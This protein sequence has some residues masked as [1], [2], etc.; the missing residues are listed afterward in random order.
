MVLVMKKSIVLAG[1]LIM[2][3]GIIVG[4]KAVQAQSPQNNNSQA[5][6]NAFNSDATTLRLSLNTLLKE[7]AILGGLMLKA[8]YR[9]EDTTRLM[10]LMN[11]NQA[12]LEQIV[13]DAYGEDTRDRFADL[14]TQHIEEYESYTIAK[15]DNDEERMNQARENLQAIS[16]EIGALFALSG[17]NLSSDDVSASMMEHINRTLNVVDATA[18]NDET[19]IVNALKGA[20][21]QAG[22]LADILSRGMI[23]D[24]PQQYPN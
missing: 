20:Y 14:W 23:L 2:M 12:Q 10:E 16:D 7:H 5:V 13:E 9:E 22:E 18:E 4:W 24:N 21:D 19:Q 17:N 6:E 3:M 15:R 8:L 1:I 11:D